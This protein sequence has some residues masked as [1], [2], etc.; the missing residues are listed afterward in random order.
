MVFDAYKVEGGKGSVE[1][2][3]GIYVIY[4]KAK[5]NPLTDVSSGPSIRLAEPTM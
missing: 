4:T 1:K 5:P 2:H 3:G